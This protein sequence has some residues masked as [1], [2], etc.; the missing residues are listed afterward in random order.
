MLGHRNDVPEILKACD[1]FVL[2]SIA[3]GLP[4]ALLEAMASGMPVIASKV[5]GVPEILSRPGLGIMVPSKSVEALSGA[6]ERMISM[7][8]TERAEVGRGLRER[9]V[10]QFSAEKMV[11]AMV[12]QYMEVM[13]ENRIG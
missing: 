9:V 4:S 10:E 13:G 11:S 3:E 5:G 6:M 7:D 12:G 8:E 2:P 1:V